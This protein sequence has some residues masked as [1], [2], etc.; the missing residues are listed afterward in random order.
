MALGIAMCCKKLAKIG[1]SDSH[2]AI[3][4]MG[5]ELTFLDPATYS[6]NRNSNHFSDLLFSEKLL[7]IEIAGHTDLPRRASLRA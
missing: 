3:K 1:V 6:A 2:Q 4:S 5:N 7:S